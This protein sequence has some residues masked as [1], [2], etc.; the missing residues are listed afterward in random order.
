MRRVRTPPF[1]AGLIIIF[2]NITGL[3][4]SAEML[5]DNVITNSVYYNYDIHS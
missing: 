4:K 5:I 1:R 3:Y 2:R